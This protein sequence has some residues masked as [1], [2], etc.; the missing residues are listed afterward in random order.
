M[1]FDNIFKPIK[2]I[3]NVYSMLDAQIPAD[4][5]QEVKEV[6]NKYV[7]DLTRYNNKVLRNIKSNGQEFI[8]EVLKEGDYLIH[9]EADEERCKKAWFLF[10]SIYNYFLYKNIIERW[11]WGMFPYAA[12]ILKSLG[13]MDYSTFTYARDL[14]ALILDTKDFGVQDLVKCFKEDMNLDTVKKSIPIIEKW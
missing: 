10:R 7:K 11:T 13:S 14:F 6:F 3:D 4:R 9:A 5:K 8:D 1:T 2:T 12:R